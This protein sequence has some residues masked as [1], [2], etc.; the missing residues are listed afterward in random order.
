MK[1][2]TQ[3]CRKCREAVRLDA[4]GASSPEQHSAIE[5]HL[6]ACADCR[7]YAGEVR[8]ATE[9]LRHLAART[10]EPSPHFRAR[11][12]SAIETADQPGPLPQALAAL[13]EWSRLMVLRN[14]RAMAALAPVWI[15]I[16]VF[17]LTAPDVGSVPPTTMACSPIEIFRALKAEESMRIALDRWNREPVPMKAPAGSPRSNRAITQPVTF[18]QEFELNPQTVFLS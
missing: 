6:L 17:R 13:I 9:G 14:R 12:T 8:A 5:Q 2:L 10:V 15:L 18:R 4:F 7:C 11:W 3:A 16:L 1:T